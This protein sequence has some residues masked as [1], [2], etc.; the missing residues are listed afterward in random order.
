MCR[1]GHALEADER[2]H[3]HDPTATPIGESLSEVPGQRHQ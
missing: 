1:A 2:T 3:E